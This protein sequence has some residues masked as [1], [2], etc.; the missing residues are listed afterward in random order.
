MIK[1][2]RT[3][4]DT[5]VVFNLLPV[6]CRDVQMH[7]S[8]PRDLSSLLDQHLTARPWSLT[9]R[10]QVSTMWRVVRIRGLQPPR[11]LTDELKNF[12]NNGCI[13]L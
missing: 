6:T 1:V 9:G 4:Y 5:H 8:R 3:H 2:R 13:W 12:N 10:T 7:T 11:E